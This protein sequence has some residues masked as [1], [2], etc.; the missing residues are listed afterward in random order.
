MKKLIPFL[1]LL[2]LLATGC[3]GSYKAVSPPSLAYPGEQTNNGLTYAYQFNVLAEAG[4]KKYAK[5]ELK[6]SVK[7]IAIKL[8]NNTGRDLDFKR[9]IDIL[10]GSEVVLPMEKEQIKQ[11]LKQPAALHML[12][13]LLFLNINDDDG[14]TTTI[15][16][17]VGIGLGNTL[18]ASGA[19][20]NLLSELTNYDILNNVIR[21]GETVYGLIGISTNITAP[22]ELRL[23]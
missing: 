20:K 22:I 19:N 12:W 21:D 13:S 17:G 23:K 8:E 6:N 1:S 7:V 2:L 3:A 18:V 14:S 15:P 4:N 5:R 16:I 9:D 11:T 10:M